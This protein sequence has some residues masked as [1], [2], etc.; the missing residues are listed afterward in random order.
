MK[1][2]N[3]TII[4]FAV[5]F[6][7]FSCKSSKNIAVDTDKPTSSNEKIAQVLAEQP[8]FITANA[9]KLNMD[10]AL[11]NKQL[12][13]AGACKM[14]RDSVIQLSIQPFMGIELFRL[15]LTP[16]AVYL[17]DKTSNKYY[18]LIYEQLT[19]LTGIP[20]TFHDFQALLSNQLFALGSSND[21]DF[22]AL[23]LLQSGGNEIF[24]YQ[25]E[26]VMQKTFFDGKNIKKVEITGTKDKF[27]FTTN[28]ADFKKT[29]EIIAPQTLKLHFEGGK[30][31]LS[32]SIKI[33][34]IE[35]NK[36]MRINLTNPLRYQKG[37]LQGFFENLLF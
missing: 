5:I 8:H 32:L 29:D 10:I 7:F 19:E 23:K 3:L 12:K 33:N 4:I 28:Y 16:E 21:K 14:Y 20:L 18:H 36:E 24:T 9:S 22:G 25:T 6:G 35:F 26:N 13:S 2:R 34:K 30:H 11:K 31:T 37:N 27:F 17:F 15:E 1:N